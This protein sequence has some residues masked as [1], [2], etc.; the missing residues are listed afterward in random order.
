[1]EPEKKDEKK[2]MESSTMGGLHDEGIDVLDSSRVAEDNEFGTPETTAAKADVITE[3]ENLPKTIPVKPVVPVPQPPKDEPLELSEES[4]KPGGSNSTSPAVPVKNDP[5]I[6]PLRTFKTDAEEAVRYQNISKT[7]M[8][9]AEQKRKETSGTPIQYDSGEKKFPLLLLATILIILMLAGGGAYYWLTTNAPAP[10]SNLPE[11]LV[12]RTL[13]PYDGITTVKL[14]PEK[15]TITLAGEAL[16]RAS[17]NIGQIYAV[18]P[19]PFGTTTVIASPSAFLANTKIPGRLIRSLSSEYMLGSYV[20]NRNA[21]FLIFKNS[22]FQNAYAGMLEWEGDMRDDL[23][24]L[25]QVAHP[26]E[27][28]ISTKS[29]V[30]EDSVVANIDA[31]ILRGSNGQPILAYAFADQ[32]TIVIATDVETLKYLIDRLLAVRIVQ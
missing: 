15:D 17:V 22:F 1:M 12:V 32:N 16:D 24:K 4:F 19:L 25:I 28:T 9:V 5:S 6:K 3:T 2:E 27:A 11:N 7:Q 18:I 31:R 13:I 14:D 10:R 23:I 21:P 8:V 26:K 29:D 30:F 20:F